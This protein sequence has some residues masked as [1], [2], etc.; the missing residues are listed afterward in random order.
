MVPITNLY[1]EGLPAAMTYIA[2]PLYAFI[3]FSYPMFHI[4]FM[5]LGYIIVLFG[6]LMIFRA[7]SSFGVDYMA[8]IYLYFPE[9]SQ[10]KNDEIYSVLRHPTY[11]A[12]I[13]IAVGGAIMNVTLYSFIF[14]LIYVIG[15][16]IHIFLVEEKE[17]ITRFGASFKEYRKKV[18]A[19][20]IKPRNL[21]TLCRFLFG[22]ME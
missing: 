4:I 17:L 19:I 20:L 1:P 22:K 21:P 14:L 9:E 13:M 18:P 11:T 7:L 12:A 16:C 6:L 3:P 10:V 15:F 5:I 8:V 2:T